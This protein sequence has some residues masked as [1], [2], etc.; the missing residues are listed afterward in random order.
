MIPLIILIASDSNIPDD[1][2][3]SNQ[4]F[5]IFSSLCVTNPSEIFVVLFYIILLLLTST[6][7]ADNLLQ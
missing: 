7:S 6:Q 4:C 5:N 3:E 2:L 1:L